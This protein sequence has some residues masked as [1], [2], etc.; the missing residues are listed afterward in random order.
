MERGE[1]SE[2]GEIL[3]VIL[4]EVE[5]AEVFQPGERPEVGDLIPVEI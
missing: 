3:D 1:G 4:L 2:R 5:S